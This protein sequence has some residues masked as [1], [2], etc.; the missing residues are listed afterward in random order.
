MAEIVLF[1]G[2]TE[3]RALAAA[4]AQK[5]LHTLVCVAS[6]YGADQLDAAHPVR[7][8]TGPLD[9]PAIAA[10]LQAET[11]RRV[12]D[13]THPYAARVSANLQNACA[14]TDTPYLRVLREQ[15]PPDG[16]AGDCT[17]FDEL[18]DLV[19]FV[20]DRPGAV[21]FSTLGAKQA[22]A[23]TG[24]SDY[25][26]RVFLRILPDPAALMD[27]LALGFCAKRIVCMQGPFSGALNAAMFRAAH[28]ELLLTKESGAAGGFLE[29]CSAARECA[30][31][32][33]VLSRP[34]EGEGVALGAL[35][36]RIEDGSL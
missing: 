13:A 31:Q 23:L 34:A 3:G 20:N 2:T 15:A 21:V 19:R 12:L 36:K 29:K 10:L 22:R 9:A 17:V 18:P 11:P 32:I 16:Y 24:V 1:A 4:L 8:H 33:A 5:G 35:L 30:M 6:G 28:A 27:C 25:A 14:A 26:K 7:V